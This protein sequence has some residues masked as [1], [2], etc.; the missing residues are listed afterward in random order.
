MGMGS[1]VF[2]S[3]KVSKATSDYIQPVHPLFLPWKWVADA[4]QSSYIYV[5]PFI[6]YIA[7]TVKDFLQQQRSTCSR[8]WSEEIPTDTYT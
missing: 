5:L 3:S 2:S 6:M 4:L 8:L 1:R 7:L